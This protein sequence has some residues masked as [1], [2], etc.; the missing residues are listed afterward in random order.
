MGHGWTPDQGACT[1]AP[2][3]CPAPPQANAT[4]RRGGFVTESATSQVRPEPPCARPCPPSPCSPSPSPPA[5]HRRHPRP[6]PTDRR[7]T[8]PPRPLR[9]KGHTSKL[10]SLMRISYAVFC[11]KKKKYNKNK[12]YNTT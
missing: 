6:P 10:Q 1:L 12:V 8:R 2:R 9:S 7:R 5:S 4:W 11:L 3:S